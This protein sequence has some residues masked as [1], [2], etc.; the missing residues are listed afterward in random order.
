MKEDTKE[1]TLVIGLKKGIKF[2]D[3]TDFTAEA[4]KWNIDQHLAVKGPGTEMLKSVD[5]LDA[6]T[7]RLNLVEW[8]NRVVEPHRSTGDDDFADGLQKERKGVGS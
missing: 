5:V 6:S 8:D 3:G 1:N 4:V 7:V 2:H